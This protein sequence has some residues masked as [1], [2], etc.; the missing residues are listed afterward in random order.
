MEFRVL[1]VLSLR[2]TDFE[3]QKSFGKSGLAETFKDLS[4]KRTH[5]VLIRQKSLLVSGVW[6]RESSLLLFG[7]W[8]FLW[9]FR[10]QQ[11]DVFDAGLWLP[12]PT[13]PQNPVPCP[14][15]RWCVSG[16]QRAPQVLPV[17]SRV[18]RGE[19]CTW[20]QGVCISKADAVI[21]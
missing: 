1:G 17:P 8:C 6:L 7:S 2:W 13:A 10:L 20:P 5:M 4:L 12:T 21:S 16:S 15:G 14:A 3:A 9:K 11:V 19:P 18:R